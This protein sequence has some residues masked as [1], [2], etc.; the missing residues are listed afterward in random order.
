M[1]RAS[2]SLDPET[3]LSAYAQGVFP[4]ADRGGIVRWYSADPRGIFP[5][6]RFHI[7]DTL[8]AVVRQGKFECRIN[9]SFEAV[10]RACMNQRRDG[11]WINE[12][13]VAAYVRLREMGFAH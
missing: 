9:H 4:M 7:P 10:M 5:L 12:S 3:L 1:H 8:A 11:T 6:D 13:L 2:V